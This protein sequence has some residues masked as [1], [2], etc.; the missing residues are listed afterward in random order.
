MKYIRMS[1]EEL[2][3]KLSKHARMIRAMRGYKKKELAMI[4]KIDVKTIDKLET[5]PIG[6]KIET[7]NT[8]A[9][10]LEV[11]IENLIMGDVFK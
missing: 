11:P 9:N 8:I 2:S 6:M 4:A 5:N 10:A 1:T 7:L 3:E